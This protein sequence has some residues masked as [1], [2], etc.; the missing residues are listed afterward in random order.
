MNRL[1]LAELEKVRQL[2]EHIPGRYITIQLDD[3]PAYLAKNGLEPMDTRSPS[4]V[5]K[6]R[7]EQVEQ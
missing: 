1:Y 7:K 5:L 4:G 6:V 2:P 3:L